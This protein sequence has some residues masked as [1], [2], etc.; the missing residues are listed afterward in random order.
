M[1]PLLFANLA[2][3]IFCTSVVSL[4]PLSTVLAQGRAKVV[5]FSKSGG[6]QI[7]AIY[8]QNGA[9]NH[10]SASATYRSGTRV[11]FIVYASGLW[12][13]QF[14]KK[15]WPKRPETR[16][17]ASLEVDGRRV[18]SGRGFFRGRSAFIDLGK[19]SKRVFALM[20]GRVMT[21]RSPSGT[22]SFRLDGTYKATFQVARCWKA[23]RKRGG[24]AFAGNNQGA[25]GN[26]ASGAFG[27]RAGTSP[28][29]ARL[30]SRAQT[31]DLATSYL[32]ATQR[33][34]TFLPA[35]KNLLKG[36]PVNWTFTDGKIGGMKVYTNTAVD[37]ARVLKRLLASQAENCNGRNATEPEPP[38]RLKKSGRLV[39]RARGI[40]QSAGGSVQ[41]IKYRVSRLRNKVL[42]IVVHVDRNS[43]PES[44]QP[45]EQRAPKPNE[46]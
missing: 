19:T 36:Y 6:W 3:S 13:L 22:S 28:G 16:F 34:Y 17:P 1:R 5:A 30:L 18:L 38:L 23:M 42:M 33:P 29:S 12:R 2:I 27:G 8:S 35:A 20:K 7:N 14:Y 37:P 32:S 10:C 44:G 41:Q 26:G 43:L 31:L 45:T 40:C 39:H 24:D 25:F 46:L 21:I 11:A 15:A 4:L 9:F